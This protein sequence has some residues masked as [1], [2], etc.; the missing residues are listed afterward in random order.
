MVGTMTRPAQPP[1]TLVESFVAVLPPECA[2]VPL[3]A[4][5]RAFWRV[6]PGRVRLGLHGVCVLLRL[7]A[8]WDGPSWGRRTP[9]ERRAVIA[10]FGASRNHLLRE[11]PVML[12]ALAAKGAFG[13]PAGQAAF[14]LPVDA[15]PP[16]W[17]P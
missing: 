11:I 14:G 16:F 15:T 17:A 2:A 13:H 10:A 4:Y 5:A 9:D 7:R 12:K 3:D 6:A 8:W 1:V